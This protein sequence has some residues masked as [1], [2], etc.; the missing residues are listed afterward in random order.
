MKFRYKKPHV[1][2]PCT[3][4]N[5]SRASRGPSSTKAWRTPPPTSTKRLLHG[6]SPPWSEKTSGGCA[7]VELDI[8]MLLRQ[9]YVMSRP[10]QRKGRRSATRGVQQRSSL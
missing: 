9:D 10:V 4:R 1:G 3:Q 7:L 6:N 8:T 5:V 2:L